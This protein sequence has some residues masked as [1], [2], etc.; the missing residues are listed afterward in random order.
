VPRLN[1]GTD[2]ALGALSAMFHDS[3]AQSIAIFFTNLKNKLALNFQEDSLPEAL[4]GDNYHSFRLNNPFAL[5]KKYYE[6]R[7]AGNPA[8]DEMEVV[9]R[10]SHEQA[11]R[12]MLRFFDWLDSLEPIPIQ[13]IRNTPGGKYEFS[14]S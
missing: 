2:Y 8:D 3:L 11:L 9:I 13:G 14:P 5:A 4:K 7:A 6:L 10:T 1:V 12:V